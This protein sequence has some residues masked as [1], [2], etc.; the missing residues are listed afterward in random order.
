M[1]PD[2]IKQVSDSTKK[3][4]EGVQ[5]AFPALKKTSVQITL[6]AT[7]VASI[8][9]IA[10]ILAFKD[11][12]VQTAQSLWAQKQVEELKDPNSLSKITSAGYDRKGDVE[13]VADKKNQANTEAPI[14]QNLPE[15][16]LP[17][18]KVS[19]AEQCN[20]PTINS[21]FPFVTKAALR[22]QLGMYCY[23]SFL[24]YYNT[25]TNTSWLTLELL[26]PANLNVAYQSTKTDVP[27]RTEPR[28]LDESPPSLEGYEGTA[29]SK[30]QVKA[31]S[32]AGCGLNCDLLNL[33]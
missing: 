23:N 31:P 14:V 30:G 22:E 20:Q 12:I 16:T 1:K 27:F 29:Y 5:L 26:T 9:A 21:R 11:E 4:W 24:A 33:V 25:K 17:R 13:E 7:G 32:Q 8:I 6:I 18:D 19:I 2:K 3:T 28:I 10:S 15:W